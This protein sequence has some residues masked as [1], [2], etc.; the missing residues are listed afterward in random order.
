ME[1]LFSTPQA[2]KLTGIPAGT[3][4][5]WLSRLTGVFE[6][7]VHIIK[8]ESGRNMWTRAG[9]EFLKTRGATEDA[10]EDDAESVECDSPVS[11]LDQLLDEG[12]EEL[13]LRY[14]QELP[15]RTL[16]R[17]TRMLQNP[18]PEERKIVTV[19]VQKAVA[20]GKLQL[21]SPKSQHRELPYAT[22]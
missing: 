13:A 9:I 19:S 1:E 16:T 20:T 18:S 3:I 22:D 8:E 5:S 10:I 21:L 14:F 7:G 17:I 15:G 12:S 2:S 11:F 4:R 6:E